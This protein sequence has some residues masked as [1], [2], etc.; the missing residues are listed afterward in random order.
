MLAG[1]LWIKATI[2]TLRIM[3]HS[4]MVSIILETASQ[5]AKKAIQTLRLWLEIS[6]RMM[7]M[8]MNIA[9][10]HLHLAPAS[11]TISL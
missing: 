6:I 11:I 4:D 7:R 1:V 8:T 2:V 5:T 10:I 9:S 3:F